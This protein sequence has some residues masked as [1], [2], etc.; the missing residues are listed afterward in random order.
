L[1]IFASVGN[2]VPSVPS[3]NLTSMGKF[4]AFSCCG[5]NYVALRARNAEDSVPYGCSD[6]HAVNNNLIYHKKA[7]YA[8]AYPA[9]VIY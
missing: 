9:S 1:F 5:A 6:Y 7:G 2:A 3:E 8:A 4:S